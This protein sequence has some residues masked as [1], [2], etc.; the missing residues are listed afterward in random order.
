MDKVYKCPNCLAELKEP[1]G[2]KLSETIKNFL[3][4]GPE[5]PLLDSV[6]VKCGLCGNITTGSELVKKQGKPY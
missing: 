2:L 6:Q 5:I 4:M 1:G 3:Q